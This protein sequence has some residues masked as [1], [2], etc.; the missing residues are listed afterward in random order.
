L[1]EI[2][3]NSKLEM[4]STSEENSDKTNFQEQNCNKYE[5]KKK[6]WNGK[7]NHY[8]LKKLKPLIRKKNVAADMPLI[9]NYP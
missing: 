5:P 9:E 3:N 2:K 7:A 1:A 4:L 8:A 6:N